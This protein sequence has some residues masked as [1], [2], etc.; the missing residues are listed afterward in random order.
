MV[1]RRY[2]Q[3]ISES[4]SNKKD[5]GIGHYSEELAML[6]SE[7]LRLKQEG[8]NENEINENIFS[9]FFS[10]LG[11]GFTDTFKD[12]VIDW[13]AEKLGIDTMDENGQPTFFYQVIRNVIEQVHFTELGKYFGKGSCKNWSVAIVEG[14]SETL[15]ERGIEYL[16]PRLGMRIDMNNGMGGTIAAGLREALTNAI[17]NTSFMNNIEKMIGD[18]ICGFKLGD[19]LSS[20]NVSTSDKQRIQ[21]E[22]ESAGEKNPD[23]YSKAMKTGLSSLLQFNK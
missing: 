20:P 19:V 12:Y 16:L 18:K 1:I 14:L 13:A 6:E 8:L 2:S 5:G 22:I 9:S 4:K 23:I 7:Y 15:Q 17:N 3:F 10:S 21:G 11:G